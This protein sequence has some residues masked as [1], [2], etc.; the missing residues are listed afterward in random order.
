MPRD[1]LAGL[2]ED[3]KQATRCLRR[4]AGSSL[5]IVCVI[6]LAI[7]VNSTVF[8]AVSAVLLGS[9]P[10]PRPDRLVRL[11]FGNQDSQARRA[12]PRDLARWA[13]S[14]E[15]FEHIA[16]YRPGVRTFA[17]DVD[18]GRALPIAEVS[19][20][21]FDVLGVHPLHGRA[22]V[23]EDETAASG[24]V[25]ILRQGAGDAGAGS[26]GDR[27][28]MLDGVRH[29]VVGTMAATFEFPDRQTVAWI[30]LVPPSAPRQAPGESVTSVQSVFGIARLKGDVSVERARI[31]AHG[32]FAS[33]DRRSMPQVA[34]MREAVGRVLGDPQGR[35]VEIAGVVGLRPPP[36]GTVDSEPEIYFYTRQGAVDVDPRVPVRFSVP[37]LPPVV[38]GVVDLYVVSSDYFQRMGLTL[39]AGEVFTDGAP[40]DVCRAGVINE[41]AAQL[42]FDGDAIGGALIDGAG[43]RT[44]I[45]GVVHDV[46]LRATQRSVEPSLYVPLAENFQPRMHLLLGSTGASVERQQGIRT[47]LAAI[48]GGNRR[49]LAVTS[50]ADSMRRTALAPERIA[51]LLL[52]VAS[53]NALAIGILG[54]YRV[55]ADDV[56]ARRREIAIRSALGARRSRLIGM[57]VVKAARLAAL[58]GIAGV[59][60]AWLLARWMSKTTGI[61]GDPILWVWLSGPAVLLAAAV[62]ASLASASSLL[63]VAPVAAMRAE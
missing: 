3:T 51:T 36:G 46:R 38:R 33:R 29:R 54:V 59:L 53:V 52:T 27:Y 15:A 17:A 43:L 19:A 23:R 16:A 24:P 31:E 4:R 21:L 9:S 26:T 56:I 5:S 55:M 13:A 39:G 34:V 30:P 47:R 22:F 10:Y 20:S 62:L 28:V 42:Y 60:A 37:I 14:G 61:G 8:S 35:R 41:Q 63:P 57:V 25:V 1:P 11:W 45:V 48:D 50:L 7:A 32:I 12:L 6:A 44:T 49:R 18:S 2:L 40:S 58:S